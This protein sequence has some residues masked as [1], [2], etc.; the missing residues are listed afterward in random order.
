[1]HHMTPG[2][3]QPLR[4][5]ILVS[6]TKLAGLR[7]A[8]TARIIMTVM[9]RPMLRIIPTTSKNSSNFVVKRL[10]IT[11]ITSTAQASKVPCHF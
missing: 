9:Y 4:S 10:A 1:M 8:M 3:L 11:G 7:G 2:L 5:K 6:K